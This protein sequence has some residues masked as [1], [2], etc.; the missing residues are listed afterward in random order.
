MKDP[1]KILSLSTNLIFGLLLTLSLAWIWKTRQ[2]PIE[3]AEANK[4]FEGYGTVYEKYIESSLRSSSRLGIEFPKV[5]MVDIEGR[6][7]STDFSD[8]KGGIILLFSPQACQPC[9]ITQLKILQFI[10][11]RLKSPS[12]LPIY[13]FANSPVFQ[14]KRFTRAF[15]LEY[16]LVSDTEEVLFTTSFSQF[17]PVVFLINQDNTIVDCHIPAVGQSNFSVLFYNTLIGHRLKEAVNVDMDLTES[18][19]SALSRS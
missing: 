5:E 19:F 1:I 14:I 6:K 4:A 8:K 18:P 12:E 16:P 3:A 10:Y 17:T 7:I 9:L 11:S 13:A 15:G 2:A